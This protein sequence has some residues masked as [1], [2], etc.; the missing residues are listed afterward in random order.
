MKTSSGVLKKAASVSSQDAFSK[1]IKQQNS[2]ESSDGEPPCLLLVVRA[3]SETYIHHVDFS[4]FDAIDLSRDE[5][6]S[7]SVGI[8]PDASFPLLVLQQRA[9]RTSEK[10]QVS[11][12]HLD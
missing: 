9:P 10:V 11:S 3:Q 2:D 6:L 1:I 7:C 12:G 8:K 4:W 5:W